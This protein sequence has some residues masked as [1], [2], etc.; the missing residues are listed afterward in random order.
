MA[1]RY[2]PTVLPD[3]FGVTVYGADCGLLA[4][5]VALLTDI[6]A[7]KVPP[8]SARRYEASARLLA[9]RDILASAAKDQEAA[10]HREIARLAQSQPSTTPVFLAPA[11]PGGSSTTATITVAQAAERLGVTGQRVRGLCAAG[12]LEASHGPRAVWEITPE[13]VA[14]YQAVRRRRTRIYEQHEG[15]SAGEPRAAA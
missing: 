5:A 10:K 9:L 3:G 6:Q 8:G 4:G 11:Q 1:Q 12:K 13:S 2:A 15:S 7:G 14:R